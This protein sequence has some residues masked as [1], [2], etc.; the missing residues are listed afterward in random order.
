MCTQFMYTVHHVQP[1]GTLANARKRKPPCI[2]AKQVPPNPGWR[3]E[4]CVE[5]CDLVSV[6]LGRIRFFTK[7]LIRVG[8]ARWEKTGK[9]H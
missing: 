3:P 5:L 4:Y 8:K 1:Q 6:Y 2:R 7:F 9:T